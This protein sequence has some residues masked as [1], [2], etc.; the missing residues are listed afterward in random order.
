MA[1]AHAPPYSH[2]RYH[3]ARLVLSPLEPSSPPVDVPTLVQLLDSVTSAWFGTM[4]GP[5]ALVQLDV[6]LVEQAHGRPAEDRE[7]V[8]RFPAG[9]THDLLTALALS[10]H[11]SFRLS[12]LRDAPDLARLGGAAGRGKAG[13]AAWLGAAREAAA[14]SGS[15]SGRGA[16]EGKETQV[17]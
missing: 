2:A 10:P 5:V 7:V 3:Y 6:V 17:G 1:I 12:I 13:Y 4:G 9:T 14:R 15:G 11:P 16:R 8:I